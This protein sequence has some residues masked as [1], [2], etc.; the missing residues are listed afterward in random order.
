[1]IRRTREDLFD[2]ET[3]LQI[4]G[5]MDET[6]LNKNCTHAE[7]RA[8]MPTKYYWD[9][10][11]CDSSMAK[12]PQSDISQADILRILT[13]A[14]LAV[15]HEACP[16]VYSSLPMEEVDVVVSE[17]DQDEEMP[18][19]NMPNEGG[20]KAS[21]LSRE[22]FKARRQHDWRSSLKLQQALE[23][24]KDALTSSSKIFFFSEF[25]SAFDALAAALTN[26]SIA[27]AKLNE[28][29][30]RDERQ[31]VVDDFESNDKSVKVL[32][33]T[34]VGGEGITL[35]K[36]SVVVILT[37]SWN[38]FIDLQIKY[39]ADRIGQ[40]LFVHTYRFMNDEFS[41][42]YV[43]RKQKMTMSSSCWM[44]QR[45]FVDSSL[46]RVHEWTEEELFG[47]SKELNS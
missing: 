47:K 2:G 12:N 14:R 26:S 32:L 41:E 4:P 20:A 7:K 23:F 25:V 37:P 39:R 1:M 31:A 15:V 11:Q 28:T 17:E 46:E 19:E 21:Q 6:L 13:N 22:E 30:N 24:S 8:Q 44:I 34:A 42:R 29:M 40:T 38:P 43:K 27:Y 3:I 35:I 10:V 5:S 16:S 45:D 18:V 36:A 9:P 33:L